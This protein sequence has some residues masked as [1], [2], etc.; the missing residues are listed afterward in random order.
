MTFFEFC[1]AGLFAAM[2]ITAAA[3][4][5]GTPP[6]GIIGA[7]GPDR[8]LARD[9]LI[10]V[11][12]HDS[13]N[14]IV[15]DVEDLIINSNNRVVGVVIGTGGVLGLGEKRVG[16]RLSSL[17]FEDADGTTHAVLS[18]ISKADLDAAPEFKR[19]KAQKSLLQSAKEKAQ[20]LTDKTTATSKSAYEKA[21]PTLDAAKESVKETYEKAKDAAAPAIDAAK[22]AI[23]PTP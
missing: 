17:N 15:G 5:T 18:D 10:G 13:S 9:N 19:A 3:A 23:S 7:Q 12:V 2:G 20:E 1:F 22:E 6:S 11:K 14:T 16:I 4:Q 21:K 8:Y